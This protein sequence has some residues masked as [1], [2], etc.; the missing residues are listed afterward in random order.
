MRSGR[1][2]LV[3]TYVYGGR[4]EVVVYRGA[5]Y[6]GF[7]YYRYV[8]RYYY[9]PA[10]YG[11]AYNPW[12]APVYWGWGWGAAPWYAYSRYYF[13]PYPVYP[14]PVLWLTDFLLAENLRAAYEAQ[15]AANVQAE[16]GAP[17]VYISKDT[18]ANAAALSPETKQAIADEVKAQL[19]AEQTAAGVPEA[20]AAP[21]Q[22]GP[23]N[24]QLPEALD[25][26]VRTFIVSRPLSEQTANGTV[27]S[28]SSGDVLT[29][30]ANTPD[31]NQNVLVLV[32]S[33]QHNDCE[34]GTQ[35]SVSLQDMQDMHNDFR[36]KLGAG[37]QMLADNQGKNGMASG[38]PADP[39]P[40]EEGQAQ[41]DANAASQLD[42]QQH[43]A[44]TAEAEV[45]QSMS[46]SPPPPP[47]DI[48]P[49]PPGNPPPPPP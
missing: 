41:P 3:R 32:T 18:N 28:L 45:R 36:Q 5:Y 40:V 2:Y 29:R 7:A 34:A 8:P 46:T 48:P 43:N 38:P 24:D 27:C 10:F 19:A 9:A 26:N 16:A 4:R 12:P 30:I 11:W 35:L 13:A 49:P 37:L 47:V 17:S 21:S 39:R 14:S 33:S 6:R 22:A 15:A 20:A 1:P 44:D 23:S 42:E 25:P 31:A